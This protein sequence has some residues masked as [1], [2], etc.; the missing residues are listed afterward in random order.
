M[1][2][3]IKTQHAQTIRRRIDELRQKAE[4][5]GVRPNQRLKVKP[6]ATVTLGLV[7]KAWTRTSKGVGSY[8]CA[9]GSTRPIRCG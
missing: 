5:E 9:G 3:G 6:K 1:I 7:I 8:S 4:L 2:D